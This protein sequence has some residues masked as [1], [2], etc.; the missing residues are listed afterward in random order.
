MNGSVQVGRVFGVP[1]RMHWSVPVLVVL[2]AY[3]LGRETLP[4]WIPGLSPTVYTVAAAAGA[5]L[6]MASLLAHEIA[7]AAT[8]RREHLSVEDVTLWAMGGM[9]RMGRPGSAGAAFLVAVSGPLASLVIG[10]AALGAGI[11]VDAAAHRSVPGALLIW[12]GWANLLLGVFNLLP[13]APLDGGRVLQA[14]LWW[15]TGDRDRADRAAGRGG[16]ILGLAFVLA[17]W[18]A[19]ARGV[20]SGLWLA[21]VGFFM[22]L[23]AGAERQRAVVN[24]ALRGVRLADAMSAPL[25]T[26]PDWLPVDRF[27]DEVAVGSRHSVLPLLDFDGRLS[28]V[29]SLRRLT[30]VPADRRGDV[31]V[32]DVAI[33]LSQCTTGAP[34]EFVNDALDRLRP[35]PGG[36]RVIVVDGGHPVGIVTGSD[37][38]RL[39]QRRRMAGGPPPA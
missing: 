15:R 32:R 20:P 26:G 22:A 9:T 23:T 3:G 2:L 16:Q 13:A 6:L 1:L 33:P 31:R 28:G 18:L 4:A 24:S 35:G 11:G 7:H 19:F 38:S 8:A 27:I 17:G 36:V 21:L 37:I 25:V 34:G 29:V 5:I 39:V 30:S 14:L 10:G 12:L